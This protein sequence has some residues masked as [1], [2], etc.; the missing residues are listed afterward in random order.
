[1]TFLA[2]LAEFTT[3]NKKKLISRQLGLQKNKLPNGGHDD[4][5]FYLSKL[6]FLMITPH[7]K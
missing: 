3:V 5:K 2:G 7:A 4:Y 6:G 1:M